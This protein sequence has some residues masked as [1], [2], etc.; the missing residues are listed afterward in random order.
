MTYTNAM[1]LRQKEGRALSKIKWLNK[2]DAE[3]RHK[4]ITETAARTYR[5]RALQ[6]SIRNKQLH[7]YKIA[8]R[9]LL[10]SYN[11]MIV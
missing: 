10:E 11:C 8:V 9:Q 3:R 2:I 7:A 1:Y 4:M 6:I 5:K